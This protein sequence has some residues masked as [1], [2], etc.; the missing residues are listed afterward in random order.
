MRY[1]SESSWQGTLGEIQRSVIKKLF[2]I[3]HSGGAN[4]A[5]GAQVAVHQRYPARSVKIC[6]HLTARS[7]RF[8]L[9]RTRFIGLYHFSQFACPNTMSHPSIKALADITFRNTLPWRD[10]QWPTP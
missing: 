1:G 8:G 7:I 10:S 2:R 6:D 5:V 3:W 9:K 4:T